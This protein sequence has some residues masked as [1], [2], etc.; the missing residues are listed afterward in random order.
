MKL[1]GRKL[2]KKDVLRACFF[3]LAML[4]L[5]IIA[6]FVL[7]ERKLMMEPTNYG[8]IPWTLYLSVGGKDKEVKFDRYDVVAFPARNMNPYIPD[9]API[10]KMVAG[11]PGDTVEVRDGNL[12][13]NGVLLGDTAYGA[14]KL[15]QPKNHWD[16]RYVL[17]K[18]EIF[19]YGSEERSYDSRYWGPYPKNLVSGR[20]TVLY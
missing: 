11:L 5:K 10:A 14:K 9:G 6:E 7:P 13:I 16:K 19:V 18:D 3:V 8:C 12:Y 2:G 1:P 20:I 15:K 17:G 4:G